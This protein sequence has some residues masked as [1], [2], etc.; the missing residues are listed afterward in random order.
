MNDFIP[1]KWCGRI[2]K[3][4]MYKDIFHQY[5]CYC[6]H[7]T[8]TDELTAKGAKEQWNAQNGEVTV[9]NSKG[10]PCYEQLAWCENRISEL[11]SLMED[12]GIY[13]VRYPG[14]Y[15]G[16]KA[17]VRA[18]DEKSAWECLKENYESLE[19]MDQCTIT[20]I[21]ADIIGVLYNDDGEY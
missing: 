15:L 13:L 3:H 14:S 1:C 12:V 2:P 19:P 10:T 5:V 18:Y 11:E 9:S 7:R 4:R 20:K 17:V 8:I 21:S 6:H 16:G